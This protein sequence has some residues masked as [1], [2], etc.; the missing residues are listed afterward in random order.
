MRLQKITCKYLTPASQQVLCKCHP[1]IL[2]HC[3]YS[4]ILM[5]FPTTVDLLAH[6]EPQ[7][8]LI[9]C[10]VAKSQSWPGPH[11][12]L[13]TSLIPCWDC[14]FSVHHGLISLISPNLPPVFF[15]KVFWSSVTS[16]RLHTVCGCFRATAPELN[17]PL[18]TKLAHPFPLLFRD[19]I[20]APC[21]HQGDQ[22]RVEKSHCQL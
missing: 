12:N 17:G 18:K 1:F 8:T 21:T 16:V 4:C 10:S 3:Y 19:C 20:P 6:I 13:R 15:N 22:V 2:P 5:T 7:H 9:S 11:C 14:S